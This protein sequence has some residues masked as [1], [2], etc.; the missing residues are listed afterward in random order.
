MGPRGITYNI[1]PVLNPPCE[2]LSPLDQTTPSPP[3]VPAERNTDAQLPTNALG[4]LHGCFNNFC[5]AQWTWMSTVV[6]N[7]RLWFE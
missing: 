4:L 6:P 2:S 1:K 3:T 7:N 5:K